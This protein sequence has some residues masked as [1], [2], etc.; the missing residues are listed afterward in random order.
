MPAGGRQSPSRIFAARKRPLVLPRPS[1]APTGSVCRYATTCSSR[2]RTRTALLDA[3]R[4]RGHNLRAGDGWCGPT[5]SR[6]SNKCRSLTEEVRE[7]GVVPV[8]CPEHRCYAMIGAASMPLRR[9]Q[10][11]SGFDPASAV[12]SRR[13]AGPSP[14]SRSYTELGA[15]TGA[16]TPRF[17]R[18]ERS[19]RADSKDRRRT[20]SR[21]LFRTRVAPSAARIIRLGDALLRR[22]SA[23]TRTPAPS[24]T[25]RV[26]RFGRAAL[27]GVPIRACSGR[28]LPRRRSPGCRAWALTPRF[29]PCLC[30]HRGPH[31]VAASPAIG[32]VVSAALSLESPRVAVSDLPALWSP[33]F[34]PADGACPPAIL[35][36][37]LVAP[38]VAARRR[39]RTDTLAIE[40]SIG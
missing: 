34:P 30:L 29:H 5:S 14:G 23:L 37:P 3:A 8:G 15:P 40:I 21:V 24:R 33:D 9:Q 20:V 38:N 39:R 4:R 17:R 28:G 19:E 7:Q 25:S 1:T 18:S 16:E 32:G 13:R 31:Q 6:R 36:P 11:E 22:S 27:D 35:R 2:P 10:N 26:R 12:A